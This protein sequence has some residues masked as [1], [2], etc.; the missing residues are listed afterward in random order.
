VARTSFRPARRPAH[1]RGFSRLDLFV[2]ISVAIIVM[3]MLLPSISW[4]REP[5]GYGNTCRNNAS[6]LAKALFGFA[7]RNGGR[8][9]GYINVLRRSDR[10]LYVDPETG[11]PT[12][13]SWVVEILSD[14][15]RQSLYEQWQR[16]NEPE[17]LPKPAQPI[18]SPKL[19]IDLLICPS[20]PASQK[21][22]TPLS[23]VVNTGLP[24]AS[25]A[26]DLP[27]AENAKGSQGPGIPR[28]WPANGVF[29][30]NY[31][32][33]QLVATPEQRRRP[34]VF[35]R[36]ELVRRPKDKVI[37]LTENVD[38]GDYTLDAVRDSADDWRRAEVNLGATWSADI[39]GPDGQLRKRPQSPAL[40]LNERTGEGN[41]N[42]MNFARPSSRHPGGINVAFVGQNVQSLSDKI[43]YFVYAKLMT[44]DDNPMHPGTRD[45]IEKLGAASLTDADIN[46]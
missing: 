31:T 3:A 35:N 5:V 26:A 29:F 45:P 12:P 20:D 15:D 1:R 43:D 46:P 28:D 33:D 24:D 22:G 25:L 38:A 37:L 10:S 6:N 9:P 34:M 27:K 18:V 8:L 19:Y 36:M 44:T 40:H 32:G 11:K 23:Y 2:V 13:V 14:I 21:I 7:N 17:K 4:V 16:V 42:D 39:V 30:D 41:G